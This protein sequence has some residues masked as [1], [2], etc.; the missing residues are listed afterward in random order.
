MG[1]TWA[2]TSQP[3]LVLEKLGDTGVVG[4]QGPGR[5]GGRGSRRA[6]GQGVCIC[7]VQWGLGEAVQHGNSCTHSR[8]PL[9]LPLVPGHAP[10]PLSWTP[11]HRTHYRLLTGPFASDSVPSNSSK[12]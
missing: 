12:T 3:E 1:P 10:A 9:T 8:Q 2:K 5:G 4:E 6:V 7:E 11:G